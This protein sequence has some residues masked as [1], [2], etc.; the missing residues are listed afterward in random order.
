MSLQVSRETLRQ[1]V[2]AEQ[3]HQPLGKY[4]TN[5]Q[6]IGNDGMGNGELLVKA[7]THSGA[8]I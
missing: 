5:L 4:S 2:A 1:Y 3:A 6:D 7:T 8:L